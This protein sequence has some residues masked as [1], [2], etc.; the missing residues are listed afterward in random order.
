MALVHYLKL[1]FLY[2]A[3]R[4]KS[5]MAYRGDFL[6][7]ALTSVLTTAINV[8]FIWVIFQNVPNLLGWKFEELLMIYGFSQLAWGIFATFFLSWTVTFPELY[9]IEG[10]L[11]R[12]LL[13]P[14]PPLFQLTMENVE[15]RQGVV[16][17]IKGAILIWYAQYAMPELTFTPWHWLLSA[18]LALLGGAIYSAMFAIFA[19]AS[20]WLKDR[21]GIVSPLFT[22][23]NAARWPL[24]IYGPA[25]ELVLTWIIPL[26]FVAFYPAAL[27]T[28]PDQYRM[29]IIAMPLMALAL[30]LL[31]SWVFARGLRVY[32]STGS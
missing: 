24:T 15:L 3:Q 14:L 13:R 9:I 4:E 17:L 16:N 31:T 10:Y 32:E 20:F 19:T 22:L 25:L 12:I 5:L 6:V 7:G 29:M 28:R 18:G 30:F 1:V 8:V 26:G 2:A 23:S 27:I 11:D 21:A